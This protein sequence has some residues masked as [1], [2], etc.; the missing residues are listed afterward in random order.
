MS[1]GS[2]RI[3]NKNQ[4]EMQASKNVPFYLKHLPTLTNPKTPNDRVMSS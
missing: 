1:A 3:E 4:E 2:R